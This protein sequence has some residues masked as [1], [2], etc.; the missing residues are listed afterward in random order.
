MQ[1][2][3]PDQQKE[4]CC[5]HWVTFSTS[6][7]RVF[8][9]QISTEVNLKSEHTLAPKSLLCLGSHALKSEAVT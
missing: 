9:G 2:S 6:K 3:C 8:S 4:N 7:N 1:S 5:G